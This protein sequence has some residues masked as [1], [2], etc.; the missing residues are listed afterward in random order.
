MQIVQ[1][2]E[3]AGVSGATLDRPG[4]SALLAAAPSHQ[5]QAVI[6][7]KL[8]RV[9]R[10]L[11]YQL[12]IEK[13]LLKS[14]VE[15]ISVAEPANGDDPTAHLMRQI[16]G[17]FAEF[18][19]ARINSRMS[20]GRKAKAKNGGY[21]GGRAAFGYRSQRGSRVLTVD[22]TAAATVRQVFA[23]R[24]QGMPLRSVA[25]TLNDRGLRTAEGAL[26]HAAQVKRVL[27]RSALYAGQYG[28]GG[29]RAERGK[30]KGILV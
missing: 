23:L 4:L 12:W 15:I 22:E 14:G 6:V 27:D 3:D 5:F 30:Q 21:A 18:E 2:F 25:A 8:D 29:I 16:I 9:A 7:A 17:A 11:M 1:T 19:K 28:Y 20:S 26:W 24:A 10:D 13:E